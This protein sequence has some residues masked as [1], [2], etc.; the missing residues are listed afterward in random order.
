MACTHGKECGRLLHDGG[1]LRQPIGIAVVN[2]GSFLLGRGVARRA[3]FHVHCLLQ[4]VEVL[5]IESLRHLL[6]HLHVELLV[7]DEAHQLL[8]LAFHRRAAVE[9]LCLERHCLQTAAGQVV[10]LGL[11]LE[12][13]VERAR[14]IEL[15]HM[16]H[17]EQQHLELRHQRHRCELAHLGLHHRIAHAGTHLGRHERV[18]PLV[19]LGREDCLQRLALGQHHLFL[20][21]LQR[22]RI[23]HDVPLQFSIDLL[24]LGECFL[25][26]VYFLHE[27]H[28]G[29]VVRA[30]DVG[31]FLQVVARNLV[32][33]LSVYAHCRHHAGG[34]RHHNSFH[35][36]FLLILLFQSLVYATKI[37]LLT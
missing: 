30:D 29:Q 14:G 18:E 32:E 2:Q 31:R 11:S 23:G 25:H 15:A 10:L 24:G 26:A 35:L 5:R 1:H 9:H 36:F 3:E 19:L 8:H 20:H 33:Q 13:L 22:V 7:V 21:S 6:Q 27:A 37:M 16:V 17:Q 34:H 4:G 28:V 12:I